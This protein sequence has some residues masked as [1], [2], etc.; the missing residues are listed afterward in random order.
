MATVQIEDGWVYTDMITGLT[1]S[2]TQGKCFGKLNITGVPGCHPRDFF[3]NLDG[4]FDGTGSLVIVPPPPEP[5]GEGGIDPFVEAVAL[6]G[7]ASAQTEA[8]LEQF[9]RMEAAFNEAVA[10]VKEQAS[11]AEKAEALLRYPAGEYGCGGPGESCLRVGCPECGMTAAKLSAYAFKQADRAEKAEAAAERAHRENVEIV[12]KA[13]ATVARLTRQAE[14]GA[15]LVGAATAWDAQRRAFYA[16]FKGEVP[17]SFTPSMSVAHDL[18]AAVAA[19]RPEA[20]ND[21]GRRVIWN[22][23]DGQEHSGVLVD[24][25]NGTLIVK[26]DDGKEVAVRGED[27]LREVPQTAL[28]AARPEATPLPCA[29][30]GGSGEI[31]LHR[32]DGETMTH[33]CGACGGKEAERVGE[34]HKCPKAIKQPCPPDV[35]GNYEMRA[36]GST[37]LIIGCNLGPDYGPHNCPGHEAESEEE[38]TDPRSDRYMWEKQDGLHPEDEEEARDE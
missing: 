38:E 27:M 5:A 16:Q 20:E 14:A 37:Y 3:F 30:C 35:P 15:G 36:D 13:E 25:D 12:A 17:C 7:R 29:Q 11:R 31:V 33:P 24:I 28:A 6:C 9:S 10:R 23:V 18:I 19:M 21:T 4:V 32:S 2:V 22:T 34:C 26:R 1:L 8:A